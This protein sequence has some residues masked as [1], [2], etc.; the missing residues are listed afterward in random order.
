MSYVKK[1]YAWYYLTM[2]YVSIFNET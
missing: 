1:E 2:Y